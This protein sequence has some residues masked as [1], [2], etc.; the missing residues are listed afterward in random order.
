MKHRITGIILAVLVV[1]IFGNYATVFGA[2]KVIKIA[3]VNN[4][5]MVL[6]KEL[7]P[8]FMEA[9]SDIEVQFIVLP[10]AVLRQSVTQDAA[11]GAGQYDIVT[12]GPYEVLSG[13]AQNAWLAP[14]NPL[15]E[16]LS[17]TE[18]DQYDANDLIKPIREAL[19]VE[20]NLYALP[21]YLTCR[22]DAGE[23]YC[24]R[25][26]QAIGSFDGPCFLGAGVF[27][28]N[29]AFALG[30]DAGCALSDRYYPSPLFSDIVL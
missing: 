27:Q 12:V 13:W 28:E 17:D 6:M 15:F 4:P 1:A 3:T 8:L 23:E 16:K 9:H 24:E 21:F 5:D 10:D 19:S 25:G 20:G 18:R 2:K 26:F 14:L 30:L 22:K 29:G 7:S 11:T